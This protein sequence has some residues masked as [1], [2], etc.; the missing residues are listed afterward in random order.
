MQSLTNPMK[1][2]NKC[3]STLRRRNN[4]EWDYFLGLLLWLFWRE[5][6]CAVFAW[7]EL[8]SSDRSMAFS[9]SIEETRGRVVDCT[10]LGVSPSPSSSPELSPSFWPPCWCTRACLRML[11]WTL[12]RRPHPGWEHWKA[13]KLNDRQL[14]HMIA[15]KHYIRF[16]PVWLLMWI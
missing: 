9:M 10:V 2:K 15:W 8:E 4:L 1:Y 7:E 11:L 6:G 16:S 12:K 13:N 5:D 14:L 3:G